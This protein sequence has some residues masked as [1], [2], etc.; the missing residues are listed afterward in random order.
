[1]AILQ[2]KITQKRCFY[3]TVAVNEH[4][5][6]IFNE[7]GHIGKI[8]KGEH[9]ESTHHTKTYSQLRRVFV[10]ETQDYFGDFPN[11]RRIRSLQVGLSLL[12]FFDARPS[13]RLE[14]SSVAC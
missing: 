7:R 10:Q 1:M 14:F 4:S 6:A 3:A 11:R 5:G 9:H 8:L 13:P 12:P 2:N